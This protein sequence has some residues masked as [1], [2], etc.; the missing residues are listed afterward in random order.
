MTTT[1][2]GRRAGDSGTKTAIHEAARRLFGTEGYDRTSIRRVA[3]EAGVDPALVVHYF[4][5]KLELFAAAAELPA[6]P[7]L[8]VTRLL[9]GP[10][11]SAGERLARF[12][13]ETLESEDGRQRMLAVVRA[14]SSEPEAARLL[15]DRISV[16][17]LEPVAAG[18]G[19]DHA[20]YRASLVMLHVV[21]LAMARYVVAV[22]PLASLPPEAVVAEL[23]PRLQT[24]LTGRLAGV[25]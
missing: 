10:R 24:C 16:D 2:R 9:D 4:G 12:V 5:S 20:A 18:I 22:E 7:E 19:G 25:E 11:R 21:G 1:K 15:R 8:V 17:L 3:I 23:A 6:P 14:A 13:V